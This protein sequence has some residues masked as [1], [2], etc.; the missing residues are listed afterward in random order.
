MKDLRIE[1]RRRDFGLVMMCLGVVGVLLFRVALGSAVC[2]GPRTASGILW[3]E[4]LF[5]GTF[6]ITRIYARE[7]PENAVLGISLM[8]GGRTVIFLAKVFL[9]LVFMQG[10][11]IVVLTLLGHGLV[12]QALHQASLFGLVLG[13]GALGI[14]SVGTFMSA[15]SYNIAGDDVVVPLLAV[16]L[17]LP[18]VVCAAQSTTDLWLGQN[19]WIWVHGLIAYDV[20]FLMLPVTLYE[21]LWEV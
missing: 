5:A 14:A 7:M 2:L 11:Q 21:L 13:L 18:V 17:Q 8:P 12:L 15:V 6:T 16:P 19:M 3:I 10:T 20:I 1:G 9:A 4:S